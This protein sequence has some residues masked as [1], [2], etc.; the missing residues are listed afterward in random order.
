MRW[1]SLSWSLCWSKGR[2]AVRMQ[3]PSCRR[4]GTSGPGRAA[5]CW[6]RTIQSMRYMWSSLLPFSSRSSCR[7]QNSRSVIPNARLMLVARSWGSC[8]RKPSPRVSVYKKEIQKSA[9]SRLGKCSR[10]DSLPLVR[11]ERGAS[12]LRACG[13]ALT[14]LPVGPI[15]PL[16]ASRHQSWAARPRFP[17]F[18]KFLPY[19]LSHKTSPSLAEISE[20]P[21]W[22]R[23]SCI[24]SH[25]SEN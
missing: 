19:A 25:M 11:S 13:M 7:N 21:F 12:S 2:G 10:S 24:S 22:P 16:R 23:Q 18:S 9:Q 20:I 5:H 3:A 4:C 6:A 1:P 14:A 17:L 8:R 15:D